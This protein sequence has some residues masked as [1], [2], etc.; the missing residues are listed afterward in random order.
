MKVLE[1]GRGWMASVVGVRS[2]LEGGVTEGDRQSI[3]N[4]WIACG[5]TLVV[6]IGIA[7]QQSRVILRHRR[8][9]QDRQARRDQEQA[10][11][12]RQERA[13]QVRI[14]KR[15]SWQAEYEEIREYQRRAEAI[16]GRIVDQPSR[17]RAVDDADLEDLGLRYEAVSRRCQALAEPLLDVATTV[18][19]LRKLTVPSDDEV[20]D[21]YRNAFAAGGVM[22]PESEWLAS[23]LGAKFVDRYCAAVDLREAIDE[24]WKALRK[25]RGD[26]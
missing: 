21:A 18:E 17:S 3:T 25:E 15:D 13:R 1:M 11:R 2:F 5:L 9:D 26:E 24:L 6:A 22:G 10:E 4:G 8:E 14:D 12:D 19:R 7:V 16:A 20:Q 23:I